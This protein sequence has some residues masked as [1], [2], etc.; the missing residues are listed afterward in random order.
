MPTTLSFAEATF[1]VGMRDASFFATDLFHEGFGQPFPRPR[2]SVGQ[3]LATPCI[4]EL[5]SLQRLIWTTE[6]VG[7]PGRPPTP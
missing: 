2:V 3:S 7:S 1:V 5:T 4:L 6:T